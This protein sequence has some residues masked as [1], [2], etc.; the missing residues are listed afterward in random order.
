MRKG[1]DASELAR[2]VA[3]LDRERQAKQ[4]RMRDPTDSGGTAMLWRRID[5]AKLR[6]EAVAIQPGVADDLHA[7]L[8]SLSAEIAWPGALATED[9]PAIAVWARVWQVRDKADLRVLLWWDCD[10]QFHGTAALLP[11]HGAA[12]PLAQTSELTA[13]LDRLAASPASS[14]SPH[15]LLLAGNRALQAGDYAAAREAYQRAIADL[16]QHPEAHRNLA[17]ALAHLGEWEAAAQ[18]MQQALRLVP[19]DT[20]LAREYLAMETDAGIAAVQQGDLMR[21]AAHFLRILNLQPDEPTALAN[22]GNIRLREGR[23]PEARAIFQRFLRC[24]PTHPIVEQI[25]LALK[26]MGEDE[27]AKDE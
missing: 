14:A 25:R 22:L 9:A 20:Q 24:N 8:S 15:G 17:L 11:L 23:L 19:P 1:I 26:E 16:P 5:S 2:L 6:A 27:Q 10:G 12:T 21:G 4:R 18:M 7:L 3:P 13:L